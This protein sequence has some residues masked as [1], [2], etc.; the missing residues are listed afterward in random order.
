[1]DEHIGEVGAEGDFGLVEPWTPGIM[2]LVRAVLN[3]KN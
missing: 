3:R 1:M 2:L